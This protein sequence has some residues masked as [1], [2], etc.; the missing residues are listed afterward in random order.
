MVM[1]ST[2]R[3]SSKSQITIPAWARRELG[4][5]PG[6]QV[7]L[8]MDGDRLVVEPV[9]RAVLDLEGS[10]RGIYGDPQAYIDELR[11]DRAS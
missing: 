1:S 2:A 3:L 9:H 6:G 10:L 11:E 5:E 4:I 7:R 8:R